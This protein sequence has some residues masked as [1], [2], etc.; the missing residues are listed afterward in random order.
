MYG[1]DTRKPRLVS[2]LRT[3]RYASRDPVPDWFVSNYHT[4]G[5]Y[6]GRANLVALFPS[7]LILAAMVAA[8]AGTLRKGRDD[9]FTVRPAELYSFLLLLIGCS[10]AGYFWFLIMYPNHGK[11]DTIKATYML[12]IFPFISIVVGILLERTKRR[13]QR[14]Y[15]V[16]LA[17]LSVVF[18]LNSYGV[19]TQN[20][21][22]L[23]S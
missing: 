18:V 4:I 13:T 9:L 14:L 21:L 1:V 8:A 16:I 17:G 19:L 5:A 12:Q 6:L 22:S 3:E 15:W 7:L 20:R 23:L 10:I 11:G 2:G